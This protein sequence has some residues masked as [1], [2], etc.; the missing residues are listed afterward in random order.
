MCY[1]RILYN[2]GQ[3][4]DGISHMGMS[5]SFH[6][7]KSHYVVGL[8]S[9]G[10]DLGVSQPDPGL[11]ALSHMSKWHGAVSFCTIHN[12]QEAFVYMWLSYVCMFQ[13]VKFI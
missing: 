10:V 11:S 5:V 4:G 8:C 6:M 7:S 1:T 2:S 3:F 9:T 12:N 13:Y